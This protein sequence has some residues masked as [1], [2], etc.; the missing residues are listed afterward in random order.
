MIREAGD[1]I[2]LEEKRNPSLSYIILLALQSLNQ[3]LKTT[4][5][6]AI[7]LKSLQIP[8]RLTNTTI[9]IWP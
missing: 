2:S 9:E 7:A 1:K 8:H 5:S 3:N 6:A 4:Y